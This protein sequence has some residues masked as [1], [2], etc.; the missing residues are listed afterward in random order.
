MKK[1]FLWSLLSVLISSSAFATTYY[2]STT[3]NNSNPGSEGSPWLTLQKCADSLSPGDTCIVEDG[4]Y[5]EDV[6]WDAR[7]GTEGN[8]VT[9]RA[10][11]KWGA[12]NVG[13]IVVDP[14]DYVVI[15]GMKNL[16]KAGGIRGIIIRGSYGWIKDC[17]VGRAEGVTLGTN[18]TAMGLS[19]GTSEGGGSTGS[20][21]SGNYITDVCFGFYIDGSNKIFENNEIYKPSLSG[22]CGDVDYMRFF[23]SGHIIRNNYMHGVDMDAVGAAHVDCFQTFDNGDFIISNITIEGNYCDTAAEGIM[24]SAATL[25][26]SSGMTIR[27][28]VFRNCGAWCACLEGIPD[29]H[30]LY[31]TCDTTG[32]LHGM[33]C[34]WD[35]AS[36]EFKGNIFYG[37]GTQYGVYLTDGSVYIDP[38][39]GGKGSYNL[40]YKPGTTLS[41][42][43]DDVQNQNPNFYDRENGNYLI[44]PDSPAKDAGISIAGWT[45]PTDR[46]GTARPSGDGWDIGAYEWVAGASPPSYRWRN[47]GI[48]GNGMMQ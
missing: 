36:C 8:P 10:R 30:I 16:L 31:N 45:S 35:G 24:A 26:T 38:G 17:Y 9:M 1:V 22:T 18:P 7:S 12:V 23:G 20:I 15:D 3:G 6:D 25:G 5:N 46:V 32:G 29:I 14:C 19:G 47:G 4:T 33:W 34:R 28:N 43:T 39:A 48:V 11:N 27:N 41:G 44:Q 13:S 2:V 37:T 21:A 42:F 40:V